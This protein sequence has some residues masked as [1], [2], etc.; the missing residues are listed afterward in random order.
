[1]SLFRVL[2][3][4]VP[5]RK[6]A[7]YA[8]AGSIKKAGVS[9]SNTSP[10]RV[11]FIYPPRVKNDAVLMGLPAFCCGGIAKRGVTSV[12]DRTN[13][14]LWIEVGVV[15]IVVLLPEYYSIVA[16]LFLPSAGSSSSPV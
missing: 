15:L 6:A 16:S 3:F 14:Q 11:D 12:A 5:S 4:I 10:N 2:R 9:N 13:R 1:M 8:T 7:Y